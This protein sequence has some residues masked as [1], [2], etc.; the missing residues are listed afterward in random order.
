M[1]EWTTKLKED[2]ERV[3]GIIK[4][5]RAEVNTGIERLKALEEERERLLNEALGV[6]DEQY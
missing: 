6:D 4:R 1:E 3:N 5:V 2:L